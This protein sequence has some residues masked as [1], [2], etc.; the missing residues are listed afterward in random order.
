MTSV[1]LN[2]TDTPWLMAASREG[3]SSLCAKLQ[4]GRVRPYTGNLLKHTPLATGS[5]QFLTMKFR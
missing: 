3:N 4:I 1:Y 5:Q 2:I